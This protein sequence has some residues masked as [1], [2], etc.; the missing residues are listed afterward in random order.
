MDFYQVCSNGGPGVKIYHA[1]GGLGFKTKIYLNVYRTA[2]FR[3]LKLGMQHL[4]MA[5][6]QICSNSCQR[7]QMTPTQ[8]GDPGFEPWKYIENIKT[9]SSSEPLGSDV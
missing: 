4:L 2:R 9:T 7:V 1:T 5:V 6:Y 8:G 3:C